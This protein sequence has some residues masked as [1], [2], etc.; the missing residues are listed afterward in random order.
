M[1]QFIENNNKLIN[2]SDK[3]IAKIDIQEQKVLR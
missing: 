1:E 3:I 2:E